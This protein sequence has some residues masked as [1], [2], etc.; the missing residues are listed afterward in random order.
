MKATGGNANGNSRSSGS[1]GSLACGVDRGRATSSRL[2]PT[3][4]EVQVA[5]QKT[6][7]EKEEA[8]Q[9]RELESDSFTAPGATA[10]SRHLATKAKGAGVR[11]PQSR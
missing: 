5:E 10:D 11:V 6:V 4:Q 1:G 8:K 7:K 3:P 2:R 9:G